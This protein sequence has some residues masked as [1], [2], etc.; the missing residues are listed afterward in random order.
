MLDSISSFLFGSFKAFAISFGRA[1]W[2]R[3]VMLFVLEGSFSYPVR[4]SIISDGLQKAMAKIRFMI[5]AYRTIR[6]SSFSE[7]AA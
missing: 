5:S 1:Y 7:R 3:E 6:P 2:C 4:W